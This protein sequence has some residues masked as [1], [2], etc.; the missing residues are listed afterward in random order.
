MF[1]YVGGRGS[2]QI[3]SAFALLCSIVHI[4][5]H[6]T[7]L[8]EYEEPEERKDID[9]HSPPQNDDQKLEELKS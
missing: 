4:L 7:V 3:F 6:A 9:Y 8:R 5:L 2:F 1:K